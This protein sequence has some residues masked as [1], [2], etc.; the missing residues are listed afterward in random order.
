[1]STLYIRGYR[2]YIEPLLMI[3]IYEFIEI[4]RAVTCAIYI[5]VYRDI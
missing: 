3:Y 1:V 2:E 5:G 4:Y